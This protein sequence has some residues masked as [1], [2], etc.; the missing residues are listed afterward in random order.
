MV[1]D[2]LQAVPTAG[3]GTEN[4]LVSF[5]R[6]GN[7]RQR[8]RLRPTLDGRN[9]QQSGICSEVALQACHESFRIQKN[10]VLQFFPQGPG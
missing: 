7:L 6:C 2:L 8:L 9:F 4:R 1:S 3:I 5:M 10:L